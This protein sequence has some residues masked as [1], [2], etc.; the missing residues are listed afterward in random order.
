MFASC[1]RKGCDQKCRSNRLNS[2]TPCLP[3]RQ[4]LIAQQEIAV[5][6]SIV[7]VHC[8]SSEIWSHFVVTT[9]W[10]PLFSQMQ[11]C[12]LSFICLYLWQIFIEIMCLGFVSVST[13]SA[14]SWS[15]WW[16]FLS[17]HQLQVMAYWDAHPKNRIAAHFMHLVTYCMKYVHF[18]RLWIIQIFQEMH[19][20][21]VLFDE[22][23]LAKTLS[24]HSQK[25]LLR[26]T[27]FLQYAKLKGKSSK[28]LNFCKFWKF[29]FLCRR[30]TFN[31]AETAFF[32][33]I[34][35]KMKAIAQP[36]P[37]SLAIIKCTANIRKNESRSTAFRIQI[38]W[39][40]KFP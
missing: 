1:N 33:S 26:I 20:N 38:Q 3:L 36:K 21:H 9:V 31:K 18:V 37:I 15:N 29:D 19:S 25:N 16:T 34:F 12:H 14:S 23:H 35:S 39:T 24:I 40:G 28:F 6:F 10:C 32:V 13:R 17:L 7:V 30:M 22:E 8:D 2:T 4:T 11:H 5:S 27:F